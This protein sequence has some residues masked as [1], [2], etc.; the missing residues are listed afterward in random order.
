MTEKKFFKYDDRRI[1][2]VDEGKGDPIIFFHGN[3]TSSFLYRNIIKNLKNQYRC[4]AADMLGM[5]DSDKLENSG[6][7]SYTFELHYKYLSEFI[8]SLELTQPVTLV[9]QDWGG[10]LAIKWA[11]ENNDNVRGIC[12]FETVIAPIKSDEMVEPTRGLFL[13]IRSEKGDKKVL[14]EK[15]GHKIK[16]N[17]YPYG[18]KSEA[19]LREFM[20]AQKIGYET[21]LTTNCYIA[22]SSN[23]YSLPR[24][25]VIE[26]MPYEF[27]NL[28]IKGLNNFFLSI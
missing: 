2:Y 22:K 10:P 1:A 20:L 27:L 14:E 23:K 18:N 9:G 24:L 21:G 25:A 6:H 13:M 15:L 17:A 28:R 26:D 4:I 12:Y 11:R 5:G 7:M 16:H 19:G 3:P 8:R